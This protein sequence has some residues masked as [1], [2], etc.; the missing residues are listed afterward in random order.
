MVGPQDV[1]IGGYLRGDRGSAPVTYRG[2]TSGPLR[3]QI[4]DSERWAGRVS[5]RSERTQ[6]IRF[7]ARGASFHE[8]RGALFGAGRLRQLRPIRGQDP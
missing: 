7:C 6:I 4:A 3:D 5:Q 8:D 1:H 2:R